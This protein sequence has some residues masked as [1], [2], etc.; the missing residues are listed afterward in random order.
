MD[1]VLPDTR[2]LRL[3]TWLVLCCKEIV[4][5]MEDLRWF[6]LLTGSEAAEQWYMRVFGMLRLG[7]TPDGLIVMGARKTHLQ[8]AGRDDQVKAS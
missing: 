4:E 7:K 8:A 3:G 6:K 5:D 1:T 2:K